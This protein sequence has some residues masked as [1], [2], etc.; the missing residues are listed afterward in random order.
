MEKNI[1]NSLEH[2]KKLV[3]RYYK[4][5][6]QFVIPLILMELGF[7]AKLDGNDFV[8]TAILFYPRTIDG[9]I[10]INLYEAVSQAHGGIFSKPTIEKSIRKAIRE[11]WE[12]RSETLWLYYF[13][14]LG[15][16]HEKPPTNHEFI[17]E[18]ARIMALWKG[19]C[20]THEYE[21]LLQRRVGHGVR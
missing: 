3:C 1:E 7:P 6:L 19:L 11:A 15:G 9:T 4:S 2:F 17:A 5:D 21:L 13:P 18:M 20:Q 16:C 10:P 12:H 8:T 14:V